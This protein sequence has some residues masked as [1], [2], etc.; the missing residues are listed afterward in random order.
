MKSL[1]EPD[2]RY[3]K[4]ARVWFKL[5]GWQDANEELVNITPQFRGPTPRL[6]GPQTGLCAVDRALGP[7]RIDRDRFPGSPAS[8]GMS[9]PAALDSHRRVYVPHTLLNP[10]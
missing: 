4:T 9:R 5:C 7:I 3:L 6:I 8:A 10:R 2:Q 1:S